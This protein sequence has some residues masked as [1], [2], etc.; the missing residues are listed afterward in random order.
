MNYRL[1]PLGW[2]AHSALRNTARSRTDG[3]NT[4]ALL[5]SPLAAGKFQRAI[6]QSGYFDSVRR[7]DAEHGPRPGAKRFGVA[8]REAVAKIGEDLGVDP[9]AYD[10]EALAHWLRGLEAA[11]F[12][13]A[14]RSLS[15]GADP[16]I[17]SADL[18]VMTN[19]RDRISLP[20]AGVFSALGHVSRYNP[21][22]IMLG[23]NR[24][25]LRLQGLLNPLLSGNILGV[26]FY[27][28]NANL[29]AMHGDILNRLWAA[30]RADRPAQRIVFGGHRKLYHYRFDWDEQGGRCLRTG[31]L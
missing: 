18:N 17:F 3:A 13:E 27:P 30:D 20:A 2:F 7:S 12:F 26:I 14:Y 24:D 4:A 11:A 5:V 6:I 22:P 25:E 16:I 10:E 9:E 15:Q 19:I 29:Y 8:A 28:L 21:V 23:T 1:G 31:R